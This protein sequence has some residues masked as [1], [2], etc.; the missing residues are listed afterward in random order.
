MFSANINTQASLFKENPLKK[1][2]LVKHITPLHKGR[3]E[4]RFARRGGG[5]FYLILNVSP[6]LNPSYPLVITFSP[7]SRPSMTS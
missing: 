7:S 1:T 4:P 2:L 5:A 6:S 3:G